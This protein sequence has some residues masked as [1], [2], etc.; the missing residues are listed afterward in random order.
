MGPPVWRPVLA[1]LAPY[2][3][4]TVYIF[5]RYLLNNFHK[6]LQSGFVWFVC[7]SL[8]W[9]STSKIHRSKSKKINFSGFRYELQNKS[10]EMAFT[11]A[12]KF[13]ISK[14]PIFFMQGSPQFYPCLHFSALVNIFWISHFWHFGDLVLTLG[15]SPISLFS[16]IW[17][18]EFTPTTNYFAV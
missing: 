8:S 6:K 12:P 7:F 16:L 4:T 5:S 3:S 9:K 18:K 15:S 10:A 11:I 2:T 14:S 13:W 1:P 17:L